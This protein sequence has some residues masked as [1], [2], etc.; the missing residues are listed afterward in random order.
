MDF[1]ELSSHLTLSMI[2]W[3]HLLRVLKLKGIS[4]TLCALH[5]QLFKLYF[6]PRDLQISPMC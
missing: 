1:I 3:E 6:M 2:K 4:W 5:V